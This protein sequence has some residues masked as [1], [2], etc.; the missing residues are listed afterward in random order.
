MGGPVRSS[1]GVTL[2]AALSVTSAFAACPSAPAS[3]CKL[4][5]G[6]KLSFHNIANDAKDQMF[7]RW[8]KGQVLS[9]SELGD[10]I[11]RSHYTLCLYAG[12]AQALAAEFPVPSGGWKDLTSGGF[13]FSSPKGDGIRFGDMRP[14]ETGKAG[15]AFKGKGNALPDPAMPLALPVTMQ[16]LAD[17]EPLCLT[18]QFSA[19]DTVT[20]SETRYKAQSKQYLPAPANTI[21]AEEECNRT[22]SVSGGVADQVGAQMRRSGTEWASSCIGYYGAQ[23]SAC[24]VSFPGDTPY[25]A[26]PDGVPS[27]TCPNTPDCDSSLGRVEW[28]AEDK[29]SRKC[30]FEQWSLVWRWI[31]SRAA[32]RAT[33]AIPPD[34][35]VNASAPAYWGVYTCYEQYFVHPLMVNMLGKLRDQPGLTPQCQGAL[36][37]RMWW[38][39]ASDWIRFGDD[40]CH[41]VYDDIAMQDACNTHTSS[42]QIDRTTVDAWCDEFSDFLRPVYEGVRGA[43]GKPF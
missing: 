15:V 18:T 28:H 31:Q 37:T 43:T 16:L 2:V 9:L 6:A 23:G 13:G 8:G 4:S 32:E 7:W 25:L 12:T 24:N 42:P 38:R 30:S 22:G 26:V 20:N 21:P 41:D 3:G 14:G 27:L 10:P 40:V 11:T 17:P 33:V 5:G 35:E 39:L 29:F 19:E 1:V 34:C 36:I